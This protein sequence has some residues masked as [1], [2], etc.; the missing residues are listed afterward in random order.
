MVALL[1]RNDAVPLWLPDLHIV[2]PRQFESRLHRF[3]PARNQ[4]DSIQRR[5]R[6]G[7][8]QIRQIFRRSRGEKPG[9]GKG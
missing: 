5:R 9:M 6:M 2:L 7:N 3:G 1:P 4:I 8:Q